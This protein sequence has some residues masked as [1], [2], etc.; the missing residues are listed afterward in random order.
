MSTLYSSE[1][2]PSAGGSALSATST[3]L[4][5]HLVSLHA[6]VTTGASLP[7]P[8]ATFQIILSA[9]PFTLDDDDAP[10]QLRPSLVL[11][12]KP[13]QTSSGVFV[14]K[15]EPTLLEGPNVHAWI[16][17]DALGADVTLDATLV[18]IA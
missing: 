9:T 6:R 10:S 17:A 3:S 4:T 7:T 14:F 15:S 11:T 16:N 1:T 12:C 5:K 8:E 13:V 18:E 2:I